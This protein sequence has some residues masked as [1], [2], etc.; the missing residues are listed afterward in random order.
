[1][2]D[3]RLGEELTFPI[4]LA[5]RL[6]SAVDEADSFKLECANI[7]NYAGL[8]LEKL[9]S[10]VRFTS[11]TQSFYERPVRRIV[12]EVCKNLERALTLVRKCKRRSVLR[13]V[14]T[15]I[16]AADFRK[17]LNHLEAS[18]GDVKWL[19]SILGFDNGGEDGLLGF[20][21]GAEDGGI[22]LTL[23][24]TAS[25]D[26]ILAWVWSS[27]AS[28]YGRPLP[29]KIEAANQLASLAQDN[30]RNKQI[31]VEEGGVPP[32]LKLLKETG[33]P[34]AQIAGANA[35]LY[36]ANDQERVRTIV[37]EQG[38][39][40]IVKVLADSPMRVQI[41]MAGLVARMAEHDSLA[42]DDFAREN[43]IRPLV[44]LLSF[45]TFSDDQMFQSGKQSIHS[46]FQI[47]KEMEKNS[48]SGL[49][50]NINHHHR[51][52]TNSFSSFHSEGSSRGGNR[53]ER[54][55]ESPEVKLKLK[56]SC[57]EALWMLASGSVSNS[58][59]IT[60]TKGLLCLAKLV[61]NEE[62]EL[63]YNCLMT[64]KEIAAA[65]E[66]NAD[67][68]RA[69]FRTNSPA[70]KAVIDQLLRV[71]K[72]LDNP[73]LQIPAIKS[74]GSLARTFPARETRV[75]G[76]LVSHLSN[77]NQE[78]AT[79]AAIALGKFACP[80]NFLRDAHCKAIVEFNGVPPL[81]KLLRGNERALVNGLILLC[82]L[83]L[84]AGNNE[85]LVQARVSTAL[86]GVEQERTV[87]AQHP[88]LRELVNKAR[89]HT[90]LYHTGTNSQRFS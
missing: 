74:I 40:L 90:N 8:L 67:L 86:E 9:R 37:N 29:E 36:L 75:I 22:V 78:V 72:E 46:I 76:P 28:I 12:A 6:R 60:D 69:A 79:E 39:P 3:K 35:L 19:G 87:V 63:Q 47:N 85:A 10:L 59:R 17:V 64:I 30:D 31:I 77:K 45:E 82:Y 51:P 20:G 13:R 42:Q 50:N 58:K 14:V 27:I 25:N 73:R 53:K 18:V 21:N 26:P 56:I 23:P 49:K 68:R 84:H 33:S 11:S 89:Y 54:E 32:F 55:N 80:D 83:V 70:A 16:S 66:S 52:Y 5:E 65:A 48:I 4:L 61:E 57:A 7:G 15:I 88:E 2:E 43:A 38:V 71:I 34:E 62:G 41:L 44:T 24:P 1:M 81:M